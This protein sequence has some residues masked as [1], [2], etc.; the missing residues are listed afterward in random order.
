MAKASKPIKAEKKKAAKKAEKKKAAK[1]A[2]K[3][4]ET[5]AFNNP[6]TKLHLEAKD[7]L[8]K[9]KDEDL[10]EKKSKEL[11]SRLKEI[12]SNN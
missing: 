5:P 1:K 11:V 4:T 10:S 12:N 6:F 9:L 3:K 2:T 8:I 7:I